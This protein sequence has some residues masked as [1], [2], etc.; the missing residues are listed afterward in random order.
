MHAAIIC[1]KF[2][3]VPCYVFLGGHAVA[4]ASGSIVAST[5]GLFYGF[6]MKQES[7]HSPDSLGKGGSDIAPYY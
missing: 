3:I 6:H 4:V 5:W 2:V 1:N 7:P